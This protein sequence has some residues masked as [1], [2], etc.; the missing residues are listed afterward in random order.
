MLY[1]LEDAA[2]AYDSIEKQLSFVTNSGIRKSKQKINQLQID[3][4]ELKQRLIDLGS[5]LKIFSDVSIDPK[6][7][8]LALQKEVLKKHESIN[9]CFINARKIVKHVKDSKLLYS[10]NRQ[11][12]Q[13]QGRD[14]KTLDDGLET[15]RIYSHAG[16][17]LTW[18]DSIH[19]LYP[20]ISEKRFHFVISSFSH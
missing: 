3:I 16:I 12:K 4:K 19:A 8:T 9:T 17:E 15:L 5:S 11:V 20:F 13:I 14:G 18:E 10:L 7:S 6:L 1:V 2:K